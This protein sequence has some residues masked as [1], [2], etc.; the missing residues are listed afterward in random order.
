MDNI[1]VLWDDQLVGRSFQKL[2]SLEV[3][4]C[5]K[6]LNIVPSRI[7]GWLKSL[8]SLNV[9]SCGLLEVVFK[10]QPL[11]P[12]DGHPIAHFPLKKL[13]LSELPELKCVWDKELYRQVK[14]QS[15]CYVS[16]WKCKS[17]ASL[18]P[19]SVAKDLIQLEELEIHQCGIVE[20]IA[21]EEGLVPRFDFSRLT[22]LKLND[23]IELKCIYTGTH[24]L[25]WPALKTLELH[26]C[27]K[28]EILAS[29]LENETPLHKRP[30]FLIEK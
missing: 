20:L 17:L 7:L 26:G 25:H 8:E 11:N 3:E 30:L 19:A 13:E 10:L 22:S 6:L 9:R 2:K 16:V 18:F 14:F 29:Q 5:N 24:T 1:E 28:V 12:L 23:L 15:L 21:K 4:R 27:N